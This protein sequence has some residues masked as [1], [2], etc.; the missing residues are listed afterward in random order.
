[1]TR[2]QLVDTIL[3]KQSYLLVGLDSDISKIPRH[4]LSYPDPIFEFN[5]Q[6]I[7]ATEKYCV[8]YK[9]NTA[10]YESSGTKGWSAMEKT[11]DLIPSTHFKI[12]DA[13]R[14]DI[15]N[16]SSHY[17]KAFFGHLNADAITVS[18]YMGEDSIRP[19]LEYENKW[20]ILLALTSN[21]GAKDF[22]ML[23]IDQEYLF[24]RILKTA[25]LWGSPENLMFVIGATQTQMI[26]QIRKIT[27][28]YFYLVPGVGAQ[29]GNL[30]EISASAIIDDVGLLVNVSRSVIYASGG[31]DFAVSAGKAAHS[32]QQE[33]K[34]FLKKTDPSRVD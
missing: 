29:G 5:R 17:A 20:T 1:M 26:R 23:R 10:F 7:Q 33:T 32:Y 28:K 8:G 15:G 24:E 34:A 22:E 21:P 9:I 3:Q 2:K 30:Q 19:F 18:P 13:K 12:A 11:F 4:L 16:T 6:I 31:E 27:P 25:T 14:A